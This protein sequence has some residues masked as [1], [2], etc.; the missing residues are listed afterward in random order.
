MKFEYNAVAEVVVE[1]RALNIGDVL[2]LEQPYETMKQ[3]D[4]ALVIDI[5]KENEV[6]W[7]LFENGVIHDGGGLVSRFPPVLEIGEIKNVM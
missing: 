6:R 4:K 1:H 7:Y 5:D 3:G 2:V